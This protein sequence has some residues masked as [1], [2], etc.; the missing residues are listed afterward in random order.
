VVGASGRTGDFGHA[1]VWQPGTITDLGTLP[2]GQASGATELNNRGQIIGW[3][4]TKNGQKH[5]VMWTLRSG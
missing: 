3:S 2:G 1:V 4:T 5:A